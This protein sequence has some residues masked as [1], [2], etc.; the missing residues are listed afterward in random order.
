MYGD[1]SIANGVEHDAVTSQ[2]SDAEPDHDAVNNSTW[3]K[4]FQDPREATERDAPMCDLVDMSR[5][6]P[7][8]D[9]VAPVYSYYD[10]GL[11]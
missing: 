9:T 3:I 2:A 4:L 11:V 6:K 8:L 7:R 5:H 1:A 10:Q